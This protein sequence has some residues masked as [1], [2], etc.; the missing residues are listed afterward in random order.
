[1]DNLDLE[2]FSK[3]VLGTAQFGLS[4]GVTNYIGKVTPLD[5][6]RIL[7]LARDLGIHT[8][9]S[10]ASY[11]D[12]EKVLGKVDSTNFEV[13]TK[14]PKVP[15]NQVMDPSWVEKSALDSLTN[16]QKKKLASLLVHAPDDLR[17][18]NS[19][20]LIDGLYAARA[21]GLTDKIGVSIYNPEDLTWILEIMSVDVVQCPLNV[22]DGR[23]ITSGWLKQL[24]RGGIEVH[25]RSVLLQGTLVAGSRAL[26]E[27]LRPWIDTFVNFENWAESQNLT[28]LQAAL[29]FPF[30]IEGIDKVLIGVVS[31]L[32]LREVALALAGP[33]VT[34]PDFFLE[35]ENLLNPVNW[36]R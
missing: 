16:L 32:Q 4:Y 15:I 11:G 8:L 36:Q 5:V 29:G 27:F 23:L 28:L 18:P 6:S 7:R 24:K 2:R 21:S 10:A 13:I 30:T 22:F 34:Y 9:D 14:L 3:L 25:V 35:D 33:S 19:R 12:A 26:P 17:G 20:H 1:M 31:P